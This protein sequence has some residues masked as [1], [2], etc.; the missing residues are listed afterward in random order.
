M[1]TMKIL[2]KM[3]LVCCLAGIVACINSCA[4][5]NL[6]GT[7]SAEKGYGG[8]GGEGGGGHGGVGGSGR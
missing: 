3:M 6:S 8:E 2:K 1:L 5:E 7:S 4:K